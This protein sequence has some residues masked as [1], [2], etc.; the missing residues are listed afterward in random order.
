M[1]LNQKRSVLITSCNAC[2][3]DDD[4]HEDAWGDQS[5]G[6]DGAVESSS[7]APADEVGEAPGLT[8]EIL[9]TPSLGFAVLPEVFMRRRKPCTLDKE[10]GFVARAFPCAS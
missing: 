10:K 2:I 7:S 8:V 6:L 3:T 5:V 9:A 4:G 1:K